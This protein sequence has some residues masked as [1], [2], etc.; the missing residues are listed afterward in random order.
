MWDTSLVQAS[1]HKRLGDRWG[2][3]CYSAHQAPPR[4]RDP[5][6]LQLRL[7]A[8][9]IVHED[10]AEDSLCGRERAAAGAAVNDGDHL[11]HAPCGTRYLLTCRDNSN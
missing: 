7:C 11:R 1:L 8:A 2:P 4:G 6:L 5:Y 3:A 9:E 10:L